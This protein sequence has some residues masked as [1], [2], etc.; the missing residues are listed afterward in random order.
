M[1]KDRGL[2][3]VI[4]HAAKAGDRHAPTMPNHNADLWVRELTSN[5]VSDLFRTLGG[6]P[7]HW[8][9]IQGV[10]N[11]GNN[12]F[13][14]TTQYGGGFNDGGRTS[15]HGKILIKWISDAIISAAKAANFDFQL[16]QL[17]FTQDT[18]WLKI[19][20]VSGKVIVVSSP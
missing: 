2:G 11:A 16:M 19:R 20:R 12:H 8:Q 17:S 10:V 6:L 13:F 7:G 14:R 5:R 4:K 18:A 15:E 3:G 1:G 9:Q